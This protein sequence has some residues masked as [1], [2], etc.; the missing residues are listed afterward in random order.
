M[1]SIGGL[2][3]VGVA[4]WTWARGKAGTG[5]GSNGVPGSSAVLTPA[6]AI[7]AVKVSNNVWLARR[8]RMRRIVRQHR[9]GR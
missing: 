4:L 1:N 8:M 2:I 5:N 9:W 3:I 7:G 6:G